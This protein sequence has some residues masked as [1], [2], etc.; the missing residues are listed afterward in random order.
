MI[1]AEQN[2]IV[3]YL[4]G[5]EGRGIGLANKIRAYEIQDRMGLDTVE[6]N[7]HLGLPVDSR[8]Y[9]SGIAI[10][11]FFKLTSVRLLTDNPLKIDAFDGSGIR[12]TERIEIK[13]PDNPISASYLETKRAK[14]GHIAPDRPNET[15]PKPTGSDALPPR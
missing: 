15:S 2:G 8:S 5:H 9:E 6:A 3:V 11:R 12:V 4:R 7:L 13:L 10:L 1:D 14:M